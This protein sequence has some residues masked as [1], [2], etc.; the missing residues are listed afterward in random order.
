MSPPKDV[1]TWRA[2]WIKPYESPWSIFE[3][4]KIANEV[5]DLDI[6]RKFGIDEVKNLRVIRP[7]H[8]DLVKM[9][10]LNEQLIKDVFG[11]DLVQRNRKNLDELIRL[12]PQDHL[13]GVVS[14]WESVYLRE[15]LY[16]CVQCLE[17]GYHSIFHQFKLLHHC[18]FHNKKLIQCCPECGSEYDYSLSNKMFD[19]PFI[20]SCGHEYCQI[21]QDQLFYDSWNQPQEHYNTLPPELLQWLT[22][23]N[24][25]KSRLKKMYFIP[26]TDFE[27]H[28]NS[29]INFLTVTN[30]A[31]NIPGHNFVESSKSIK[32]IR[33]FEEKK[34][35]FKYSKKG[36]FSNLNE[37]YIKKARFD[38]LQKE[39]YQNYKRIIAGVSKHIRQTILAEHKSCLY[40]LKN[41]KGRGPICSYAYAYIAWRRT[42]QNFDHFSL[43]DNM[44]RPKRLN[45]PIFEFPS[46]AYFLYD[47]YDQ[48]NNQIDDIT[49][50]SRAATKWLLNRILDQFL[51][52]WFDNWLQHSKEFIS[53]GIMPAVP[54][55]EDK[56]PLFIAV[57]SNESNEELEFHWWDDKRE[58]NELAC[59]FSNNK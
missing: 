51:L 42:I 39:F 47:L 45:K 56:Y 14:P 25:Q 32:T 43:V 52:K 57:F 7:S 50:S 21:N 46:S 49:L 40:E 13:L 23:T 30:K 38:I 9:F 34:F 55:F 1:Y 6:I 33:S 44:G 22:L 3:K 35:A 10:S 2:N 20:C 27:K 19:S 17:Q 37:F 4:F 11:I 31:N 48:W 59:P 24:H 58:Y 29:L 5:L 28:P 18:P 54:Q 26:Q 53:E 15:K 12:L 41:F 16:F 36:D 8:Y